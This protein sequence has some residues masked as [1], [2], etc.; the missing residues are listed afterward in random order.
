MP[1]AS[2][3]DVVVDSDAQALGDRDDVQG[4]LDVLGRW[5]RI[6]RRVIVN[7]TTEFL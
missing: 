2:D 6:A 5:R 1:V 7:Q 3:D 4:H